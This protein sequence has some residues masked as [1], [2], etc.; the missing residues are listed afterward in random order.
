MILEA[1]GCGG[2]MEGWRFRETGFYRGR[3]PN[4]HVET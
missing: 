1:D 2:G 4:S 3:A